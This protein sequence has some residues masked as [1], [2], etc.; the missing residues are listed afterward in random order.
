MSRCAVILSIA[1]ALPY[2]QQA[3][4]VEKLYTG[5][6]GLI[7]TAALCKKPTEQNIF[8]GLL[9]ALQEDINAISA[10][11]EK[12]FKEKVFANHLIFVAEGASAVGWVTVV[13]S[14]CV[15]HETLD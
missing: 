8:A 3:K 9:Q 15:Y 4:V 13:G 1:G 5:L 11:K 12:N 10:I 14:S 2:I 7:R 6:G